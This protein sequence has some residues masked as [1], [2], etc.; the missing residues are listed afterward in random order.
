MAYRPIQ[1][2]LVEVKLKGEPLGD[3]LSAR[4]VEPIVLLQ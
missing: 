3:A 4:T 2:S 1:V